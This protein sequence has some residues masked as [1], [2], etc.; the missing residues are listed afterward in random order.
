MPLYRSHRDLAV[1]LPFTLTH[2]KPPPTPSPSRQLDFM[3]NPLS[4]D[5]LQA[6]DVPVDLNLI[7]LDAK[8]DILP[9]PSL[10]RS[11]ERMFLYLVSMELVTMMI[12]S[13]KN[14][15]EYVSKAT[16]KVST[17]QKRNGGLSANDAN[18][19]MSSESLHHFSNANRSDWVFVNTYRCLM[20]L[21]SRLFVTSEKN[22]KK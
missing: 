10:A 7:Q 8:F 9:C 21:S 5:G 19:D 4:S 12:S 18:E 3:S 2:P 22:I 13:L 16:K 11:I 14:S 1:E 6:G 15:L 17:I 20:Y